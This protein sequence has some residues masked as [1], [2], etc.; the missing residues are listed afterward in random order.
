MNKMAGGAKV[1]DKQD[2][3]KAAKENDVKFIRLWFTDILGFL[4]SFAITVEELEEGLEDG[5]GFDGSSI[6]GFARIDESDMV[7]LPD[8]NTFQIL[9]WRPMERGVARM[10]CD[11]LLP[12][13]Q[14]FEGDPR[15]ILKKN[16][17][18]AADLGYTLYV[19]PELEYF[20]FEDS[21]STKPLDEGGY[22]DLTPPDV[23]SELRKE[24][25]LALEELGIKVEYSHHEVAPSQHEIDLKYADALT[26]AD[27][28]M[29][30]R[31]VV[32]EVAMKHGVYATFMPKPIFGVNGSGMHTHMSLF[33]G[34]RNAFF[35]KDDEHHLS[36]VAKHYIA[37]LLRYAPEIT[38]VTSQWVNSYKR[39]VSGYEAPIYV[40][41]ARRNRSDLIRVPE[42]KPGKESDTRVEF[43]S[44]DPACN[45][46]LAFSV[47]LAAGLEGVEREYELPDPV[48][49]N[50]FEMSEKERIRRGIGTLPG[51]LWEAILLTKDSDLVRRCLGDHVFSS[52]IRNKEIEWANYRS[53]VTDYELKRYLPI[54]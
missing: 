35:D 29:T 2:V 26:M 1:K 33:K 28:V 27:N 46:Y 17:K 9:P 40:T 7:A 34:D 41:W 16:L 36:K 10:F 20:Y 14:P 32:K 19:G 18:R 4:K 22:F 30:Y 50:V 43:R 48:E 11:I 54:L 52:F 45:P 37:G 13:G 8:P 21:K 5:M 44:P 49:E 15:Y 23:A 25:V 51:S 24:T 12:G 47:M 31:L 53:Q 38:A 3:L 6:Q 42:Y 39:L